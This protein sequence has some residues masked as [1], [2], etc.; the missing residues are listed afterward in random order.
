[1]KYINIILILCLLLLLCIWYNKNCVKKEHLTY[2]NNCY[3]TLE[4]EIQI[5]KE[6]D[7]KYYN[8]VAPDERITNSYNQRDTDVYCIFSTI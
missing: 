2:T 1:M 7:C 3:N 5:L 8:S 4:D 6:L